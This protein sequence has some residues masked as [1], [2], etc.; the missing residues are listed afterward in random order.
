LP[1]YE[2]TGGFGV[3]QSRLLLTSFC[4]SIH[5]FLYLLRVTLAALKIYFND[6]LLGR[7]KLLLEYG[8]VGLL[9]FGGLEKIEVD[10]SE[11]SPG[12]LAIWTR[13]GMPRFVESQIGRIEMLLVLLNFLDEFDGYRVKLVLEHFDAEAC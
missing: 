2:G 4:G 13:I 7:F 10:I 9:V 8:N 12:S 5:L 1:L 11:R 6:S 3:L